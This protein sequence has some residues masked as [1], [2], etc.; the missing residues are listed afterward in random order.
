MQTKSTPA[1]FFL[2]HPAGGD[3]FQWREGNIKGKKLDCQIILMQQQVQQIESYNFSAV[4]LGQV[5]DMVL[6]NYSNLKDL[7]PCVQTKNNLDGNWL[8]KHIEHIKRASQK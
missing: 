6:F 8:S 2:C 7:Y 5:L 1:G 3:N 4:W